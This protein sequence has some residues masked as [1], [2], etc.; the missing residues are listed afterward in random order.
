[1]VAPRRDVEVAVISN[2]HRLDGGRKR[3]RSAP[4]GSILRPM[5][6]EF[7][8]ARWSEG[9]IGF[10][11]G[12]PNAL[13][14][15]Q[16]GVL[17]KE[18]RVLVPLCGKSED[19]AFLAAHGHEVVGIELVESAVRDFFREHGMKPEI[20]ASGPFKRYETPGLTLLV[21][22]VFDAT[23][24]HVGRVNALYDRAALVALPSSLR[25]R[26]ARHLRGL[27]V[28]GSN[29]LVITMEVEKESDEG[30][31]FSIPQEMLQAL[32]Q[33]LEVRLL[34]SSP[35]EDGRLRDLHAIN[36]A[37]SVGF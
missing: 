29:G 4:T 12:H 18:R 28:P 34:E 3:L 13:L 23:A 9:R 17:G 15:R 5:D 25:E 2:H 19:L 21:G 36:H 37:F 14:A 16:A 31:P 33:G 35:A 32:Y 24:E 22:D 1:M 30:P 26:Y 10:H 20:S 11:E 8:R 6:P 7:W 27:L